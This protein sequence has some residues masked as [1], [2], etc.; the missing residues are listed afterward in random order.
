MKKCIVVKGVQ[1]RHSLVL[2]GPGAGVHCVFCQTPWRNRA[3][4]LDAIACSDAWERTRFP[5]GAEW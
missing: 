2:D 5:E 3:D 1:F 4:A